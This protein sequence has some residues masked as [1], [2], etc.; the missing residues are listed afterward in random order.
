MNDII[1]ARSASGI[2][3]ASAASATQESGASCNRRRV[4]HLS[5]APV[6]PQVRSDAGVLVEDLHGP[7]LDPNVDLAAGQRV[8]RLCGLRVSSNAAIIGTSSVSWTVMI[9]EIPVVTISNPKQDMTPDRIRAI[10]DQLRLTQEEAGALLGGG[11]RAFTKYESGSMRPRAAASNLLRVLEAHPEVMWVLRGEKAPPAVGAPSPFGVQGENLGGLR[12]EQ[13][14]E[15]LGRILSV[16]AQANGIPLDGI[17]V[18]SNIAAPDG[19][20]DGRISWQD[21]PERT[22][23]LPSRLS[24]FQLKAGG[25]QP[26]RAGQEVLARGEV[27]PMVRS[28]LEQGGHYLM[29]CARRYTRSEIENREQAIHKALL[30]AGLSV[31]PERISFRD[32]DM[33]ALWVSAHPSVALWVQER[34]GL[35]RAGLFMSWSHW[36]GRSEHA[37]PWVEDLRLPELRRVFREQLTQP[38][39]A[40]RGGGIVGR[41]QVAALSRGLGRDL[42]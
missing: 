4:G 17:H 1:P 31:P 6:D 13:L 25:I 3:H 42:R 2:C 7:G 8:G 20:E 32:A 18:S 30:E 29:L 12:P 16:E 5:A 34:V 33:I 38:R 36:R 11:A 21:G 24:Q 19:G 39:T 26:A 41:R 40:L 35:A 23:F 15:L 10:R 37:V 27:K 14:H 22:A 28:V 9:Q